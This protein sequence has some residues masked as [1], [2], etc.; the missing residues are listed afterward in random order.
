MAVLLLWQ[1]IFLFFFFLCWTQEGRMKVHGRKRNTVW[2][3]KLNC[4]V[5]IV[6]LP[7][8][9]SF[10]D[11]S[12]LHMNQQLASIMRLASLLISIL[13]FSLYH[14]TFISLPLPFKNQSS[15]FYIYAMSMFLPFFHFDLFFSFL[16]DFFYPMKLWDSY[17][18]FSRISKNHF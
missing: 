7:L 18:P 5:P 17:G 16:L 15:F 1:A 6:G 8:L 10:S 9:L 2:V 3:N 14:F 4:P 11:S 12:R 13:G